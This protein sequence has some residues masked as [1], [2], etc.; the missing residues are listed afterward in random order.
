MSRRKLKSDRELI[1]DL[2]DRIKLFCD[3][4]YDP[5]IKGCNKCP[6]VTLGFTDCRVAYI[7]YLLNKG[8]V[9]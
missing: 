4:W 7:H 2:T 9:E 5:A 8:E 1:A 6:L 3:S